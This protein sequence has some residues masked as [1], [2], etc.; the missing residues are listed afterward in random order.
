MIPQLCLGTA[1]FGTAYGITNTEGQVS[2]PEVGRVL[3]YANEAGISFLDTAQAYGNAECVLGRQLPTSHA[4]RIISKLSAQSQHVFT[5]QDS[6]LWEQCL[7]NSCN[8]LGVASLEA[9]LLHSPA[10]LCKPGGH[11]LEGWLMGLRERGLVQRIG[12]SIYEA[13]DLNG[14]NPDLL[15]IVQ[16]P[17][18]LFDQRLLQNGT[19]TRLRDC[20]TA[21]HARSIYL[22]GLLLTPV[23]QWPRW[24]SAELR[25]HQQAL[26]QMAY[27]RNCDL[28]DLCLG[29]A[30]QQMDIETVV[31]GVRNV[32]DVEALCHAWAKP[33][34]WI[35]TE[36]KTWAFME[37]KLLD[38]RTWRPN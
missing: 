3:A 31:V 19:L 18:S 25:F 38:P 32:Q 12:V 5:A 17:L 28:I 11:Y 13:E 4:F 30:K 23:V 6:E 36:W 10:D 15:D 1:Q 27:E 8:R 33:T 2:E 20:G 22:Q 21:I 37:S 16:L 29:F 9:L 14:L 34:P 24:L 26:Q 7:L 35:D